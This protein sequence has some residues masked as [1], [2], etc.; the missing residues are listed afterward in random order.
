MVAGSEETVALTTRPKPTVLIRLP[1]DPHMRWW[2]VRLRLATGRRPHW[3]E[4]ILITV[5]GGPQARADQEDG[6]NGATRVST[7]Q[8]SRFAM[9]PGSS[10]QREGRVM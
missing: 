4:E 1:T 10:V 3:K 7:V 6:G 8:L 2:A 9:E 5:Q